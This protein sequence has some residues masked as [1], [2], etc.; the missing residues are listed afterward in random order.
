MK[1]LGRRTPTI[2]NLAW[3]EAFFWDGRAETLEEQALGPITSPGEM[4]LPTN[5][6]LDKLISIPE[7]RALFH[8]A[9]R[10]EPI[11]ENLIA[12]A[13]ATF[14]RS[15]V[16]GMAP[17]DRWLDGDNAA[18]SAEAKRGFIIPRPA[19]KKIFRVR[20]KRQVPI[21]V[22]AFTSAPGEVIDERF[23]GKTLSF[24]SARVMR[25]PM[26]FKREI[27][28]GVRRVLPDRFVA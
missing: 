16:S 21:E 18:V 3:S 12:K 13:I 15:V 22:P 11:N 24:V 5:K 19:I 2:L 1:E 10:E 23:A 25:I 17:F 7:Y 9:Y 28:P 27:N 8:K 20:M 14:E 4:N 26:V 6:L